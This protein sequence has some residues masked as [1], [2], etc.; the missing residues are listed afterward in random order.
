M[1]TASLKQRI[2]ELQA[3]NNYLRS[4]CESFDTGNVPQGASL[5]HLI[6]AKWGRVRLEDKKKTPA[7][8]Q[9]K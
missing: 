8:L 7:L 4:L 2:L 5:K 6:Y 1:N 3:E 9:T